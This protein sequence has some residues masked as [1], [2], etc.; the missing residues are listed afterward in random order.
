[1][2]AAAALALVLAGCSDHHRA[3]AAPTTVPTTTIPPTTTTQ[4]PPVLPLTGLP[5]SS[6]GQLH[7]PAVVVKIDNVDAARPQTGINRADVVY[8]EEVEGGLT[9]LAA[10]FQSYYPSVV[11]PVRSGRLTDEG[12]AD[13]LNF[14][15]YAY[16]GT[17]GI[18]E[19]VLRAQPL[20]AV[21]DSNYPSQFYRVGSNVPH[22]L[23]TDVVNLAKLSTSH[24]Y[25]SPLFSF[26]SAGEPF[27][28][29]SA[30]AANRLSI[31]FPAAVVTWTYDR[32]TD[33]WLRDQNGTADIDSAGHQAS[34]TNVI[35]MSV[36]YVVSG[37]ATGE[38]LPPTPIPD[39]VLT[40][41][42]PVW[43]FSAGRVVK[44]TW[45]RSALTTPAT[46]HD[47]SGATIRL[48]PGR[49]WVE[50]VPIGVTPQVG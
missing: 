48:T 25:P 5:P 46:Y 43:V 42:G 45:H 12:I 40:G 6:L 37:M 17:N 3:A 16:S 26:R 41:G 19:P 27:G 24:R 4:P 39:G 32:A 14:P 28:G 29:A 50:L 15:V 13:D 9:R 11:G 36:N 35:V 1:V 31:S 33:S 21:D 20:T 2:A 22:N 10:V 8:E 23:F 47:A 49:T 18:F 38:G 44:G 34:A 7:Q 30:A